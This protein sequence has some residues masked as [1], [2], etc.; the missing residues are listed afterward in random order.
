MKLKKEELKLQYASNLED[1]DSA[2]KNELTEGQIKF[3]DSRYGKPD[4]T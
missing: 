4:Q 2:R 3:L 1:F